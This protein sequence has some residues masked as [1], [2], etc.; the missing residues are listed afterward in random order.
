MRKFNQT[1]ILPVFFIALHGA[2]HA[3]VPAE[4]AASLKSTLTPLGGERAANK[5]GSI[6]EW[7]GGLSTG[8]TSGTLPPKLFTEEK[9]L[10]SISASN[11]DQYAAQLSEG[12]T[13][14]LKT[15]PGFRIDVYKTHRTASTPAHI[16]ERT[17]A[18]ATKVKM[19]KRVISGD[20][21]GGTP[22]PI[23]KS[24][25]EAIMNTQYV[26]RGL[27]RE[28]TASTWV[29]SSSGKR[30]LA[31]TLRS[32]ESFP[33]DYPNTQPDPWDGKVRYA[34]L[35]ETI[36][37]AHQA[38]EKILA[39]IPK[40]ISE[41][42]SAWIYLTG[43]RRVRKSPNIEYDVPSVFTSGITNY[44]DQDGFQGA[45]DRYDWKLKGKQEMIVPYNT[46][47]LYH[48]ADLDKVLGA[49]FMNPDLVRWELHRVWVLE[50]TLKQGSRHVVP[51][52]V[53]YVDEDTWRIVMS[54]QWDAKGQCWKFIQLN[55]IVRQDMGVTNASNVIYNL[56]SR[57]YTAFNLPNGGG[58]YVYKATDPKLFTAQSLESAGVR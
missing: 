45:E 53:L 44:D 40:Q 19:E 42:P 11:A 36:A 47:S 33:I 30:T 55:T 1:I 29:V 2:A 10:F 48:E 27:D 9:P 28:F 5:A 22:F 41:T 37:P 50:G 16:N 20:F 23:P 35:A 49:K 7:K 26:W 51:R 46:N 17:F 14:L 25:L 4:E 18:N 21:K 8:G 58:G 52:R 31:T 15:Y 13:L 43:Q 38:G 54:D 6:P 57:A 12:Q 24:G 32:R 56:Q 39:L 3:A 34:V